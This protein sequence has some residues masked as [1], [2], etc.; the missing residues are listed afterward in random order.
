MYPEHNMEKSLSIVL[1]YHNKR[2]NLP[3]IIEQ[4]ENALLKTYKQN[5]TDNVEVV[6]VNNDS[7]NNTKQ[8]L[9]EQQHE[10]PLVVVS[11]DKRQKYNTAVHNELTKTQNTRVA[12]INN[13][14]QFEPIQIINMLLLINAQ[15]TN[16]IT[17]IR[18]DHQNS[19]YHQNINWIY[20]VAVRH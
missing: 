14:K 2:E 3:T 11:H 16:I 5:Q 19:M 18:T 1:L 6:V 13:N 15:Q 17:N 8:W 4:V 7:T 12:Y 10:V 20:N 9:H